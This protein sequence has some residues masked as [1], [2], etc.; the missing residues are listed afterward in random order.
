M[1]I[2]PA[3][4]IK[5][6][7]VVRLTQGKFDQQT[8]YHEDPVLLARS[9]EDQGA[10]LIHI[11][12][13]DGAEKGSLVNLKTIQS[14]KKTL[15]I[16]IQVGGGIRDEE[17]VNRLLSEGIHRVILGTKAAEDLRFLKKVISKWGDHIAV[18]IDCIKGHVMTKGWTKSSNIQGTAL[19]KTLQDC[20]LKMLVYTDI[21]R[22]GVL[23][24]PNIEEVKKMLNIISIDMIASGG[25]AN[26]KDIESILALKNHN[27][28]GVIIGKAL[29]EK[30]F[31]L[32]EAI[33]LCSQKE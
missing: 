3:I 17:A 31:T 13:L 12:D 8:I 10:K 16:P 28:Y 20:G 14:I 22:D 15:N 1:I 5:N 27:L 24:G 26:L 4:D 21:S 11:V 25:V 33:D 7:K 29:Y 23:S 9:W 6:K 19:A 18:S 32:R 30:K 2:I